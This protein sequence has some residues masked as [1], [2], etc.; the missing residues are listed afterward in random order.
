M[1]LLI[2]ILTSAFALGVTAH[3][4]DLTR[5][6]CPA[7]FP[8]CYQHHPPTAIANPAELSSQ[9]TEALDSSQPTPSGSGGACPHYGCEIQPHR[10]TNLIQR[11]PG[12]VVP[13]SV[14]GD[15][16]QQRPSTSRA[17]PTPPVPGDT[18]SKKCQAHPSRAQPTPVPGFEPSVLQKEKRQGGWHT[19]EKRQGGWHTLEKR[20]GGWHTLENRQGGWHTL[21]NRQGGWH[22]LASGSSPH[23]TAT[24]SEK[25]STWDLGEP[26]SAWDI[27]PTNFPEPSVNPT[28]KWDIGEPSSTWDIL[29]T[30]FPHATLNPSSIWDILPTTSTTSSTADVHTQDLKRQVTSTAAE[31]TPTYI[32]VH[33]VAHVDVDDCCRRSQPALRCL[34]CP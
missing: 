27:L 16:E 32:P 22:A 24:Q 12:P 11:T 19:M 21:G 10:W 23:L 5:T 13:T 4:A 26:S 8:Q 25:S 20:Q 30:S 2:L 18:T 6:L 31:R 33:A 34:H 15:E 28:S 7:D 1:D 14:A 29:P 17:L 3:P 9:T